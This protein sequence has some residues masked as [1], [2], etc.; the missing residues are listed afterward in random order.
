[1][2][3][4]IQNVAI[5]LA[6]IVVHDQVNRA[7]RDRLTLSRVISGILFGGFTIVGMLTPMEFAPG[8]IYDGRSIILGAAGYMGG[9]IPASISALISGGFRLY[10]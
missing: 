3:S 5:L 6:L 4:L 7:L 9:W 10:L 2:L 1:M 8:V